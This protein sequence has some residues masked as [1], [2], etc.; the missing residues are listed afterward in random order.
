ML[1]TL[2]TSSTLAVAVVMSGCAG[3]E[4]LH[5]SSNAS[6]KESIGLYN[7]TWV[8]TQI[9]GVEIESNALS[10]K[11]PSIQ[12]DAQAKRFSGADGCNKIFGSFE[13]NAKQLQLGPIASTKM[14][15]IGNDN[16]TLSRQYSD[17]LTNTASYKIKGHELQFLDSS[18]KALV[19]FMTV[20]QPL[21]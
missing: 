1:K 19:S 12:L 21:P 9:N 4:S 6:Q 2:L 7:R 20:T 16:A 10:G 11:Q 17:A 8:A 5:T 14:A 15:C 3:T 13:S 18:G